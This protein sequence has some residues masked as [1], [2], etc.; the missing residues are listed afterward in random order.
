MEKN[1]N[2]LNQLNEPGVQSEAERLQITGKEL[3]EILGK[4]GLS[5]KEYGE[6]IGKSR[7][8][9]C[10]MISAPGKIKIRFSRILQKA[11][12]S[13]IFNMLLMQYREK[14]AKRLEH[15]IKFRAVRIEAERLKQEKKEE[16]RLK[17]LEMSKLSSKKCE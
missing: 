15:E 10:R 6:L 13:E 17:K 11:I 14:K 1:T 3:K 7:I 9:V 5:Q 8:S 16:K 2:N 4:F 12:G